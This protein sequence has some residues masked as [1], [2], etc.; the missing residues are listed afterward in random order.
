MAATS[1]SN[2]LVQNTL[3]LWFRV[4]LA[5]NTC[6]KHF[7]LEKLKPPATAIWKPQIYRQQ[8]LRTLVSHSRAP[9]GVDTPAVWPR[10][11]WRTILRQATVIRI[12]TETGDRMTPMAPSRQGLREMETRRRA[13]MNDPASA[14][15]PYCNHRKGGA[16]KGALC[17]S[18]VQVASSSRVLSD[19]HQAL[20]ET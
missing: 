4:M 19:I 18:E 2:R 12:V 8:A 20:H 14:A 9:Q 10:S 3:A 11:T 13:R 1:H 7:R 6:Q 15:N 17:G 5:N 16:L